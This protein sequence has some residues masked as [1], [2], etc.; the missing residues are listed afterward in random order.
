MKGTVNETMGMRI[1]KRRAVLAMSQ[2]DLA[3]IM[4]VPKTTISSYENDR[5]DI[6]GSVIIELAR[7]LGTTPDYLLLGRDNENVTDPYLEKMMSLL[8]RLKDEKARELLAVQ[9]SALVNGVR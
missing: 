9:V 4:N 7:S 6:K 8:Q 3:E 2:D 5:I 1:K